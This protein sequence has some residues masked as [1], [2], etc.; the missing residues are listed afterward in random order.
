MRNLAE[1]TARTGNFRPDIQGLRA[2]AIA[3][4]VLYHTGILEIHNGVIVSFVLSGYLIGSQL[5]AE[6][7]KTG[8]V[9]FGKFWARRMRRLAPGMAVVVIAT[10]VASW[11][12]ASPLRFREYANDGLLSVFSVLNW[13]LAE[14]GTDYFANNGT[15]TPFQHAWSLNIEEQFYL[16]FP[17]LLLAVA[18]LS[19]KIFRNRA[20]I[21]VMLIGVIGGSLF[22]A[23]T[24]TVSNQPL[25][26][27]G[28]QTRAWELAAGVLLALGTKLLSRMNTVLAVVMSWAGLATIIVTGLLITDH[29]PLPGYADIGT[30]VG[31][32]MLIAGGCAAPTF[33]AEWLLKRKPFDFV[34]NV[35]YGWYLWHWPLL[36]LWPD[37]TGHDITF[38]DRLR[39]AGFS[40][41]LATVMFYAIEK[42]I[43]ANKRLTL[44]PWRGITL[45]TG[46]T[47]TAAAAMALAFVVPLNIPASTPAVTAAADNNINVVGLADVK[48]AAY[49]QDLPSNV[50]PGLVDAPNDATHFG[51]IDNTDVTTYKLTSNCIIGDKT[52]DRTIVVIGDS[53]AWQWGDAFNSLGKDLGVR[54]VTM[55]KGGCSPEVYA[56]QNPQLNREYSECDS[57]RQSAFDEMDRLHPQVII[58]TSRVRQET[59]QAGAEQTFARLSKISGAKL[60]YMT[61]TPHPGIN[62]PD[63]LA[64][65]TSEVKACNRSVDQAVE[66]PQAREIEQAAAR[67]Y[68]AVVFDTL[69]AFCT[70]TTCP[71][72]I[73]GRIVYFDDSHMTRSYSL[74]LTSFVEPPLRVALS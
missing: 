9:S 64:K 23:I 67:K 46:L 58:V 53:H 66:F 48:E 13:H 43:R 26:Y 45:G 16:V 6:V 32:A 71:P 47:A 44:Q 39:V 57:W 29:T 25:A 5:L 72:V 56:I 8:R 68:G 37:I 18:W 70:A 4:V 11:V 31:A 17:I 36:I 49:Q 15:Q 50:Q 42:R 3:M 61:D 40:L 14:N 2:V 1:T 10:I 65:H 69:P 27:F 51:C 41:F 19:K 33:G 28:A 73:G 21:A 7:G 62:I 22:L 74:A 54:V 52:S 30:V 24:Q 35:S 55:A 59:T 20:L 12:W 38:S 34:A 60:V 63:C